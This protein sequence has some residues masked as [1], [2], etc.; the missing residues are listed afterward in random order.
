MGQVS[1][2]RLEHMQVGKTK[3]GNVVGDNEHRNDYSD[4]FMHFLSSW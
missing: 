1:G 2:H 4:G 3:A